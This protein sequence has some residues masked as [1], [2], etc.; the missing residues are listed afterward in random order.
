[1]TGQSAVGDLW[2]RIRALNAIVLGEDPAEFFKPPRPAKVVSAVESKLGFVVP[3]E[4][5]ASYAIY[6]EVTQPWDDC[7]FFHAVE[8]LPA[9]V[10]GYTEW[11]KHCPP[12]RCSAGAR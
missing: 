2:P 10:P 6:D 11:S 9:A 7:A 12:F 1:M 8:D 3:D 5:R 4:L